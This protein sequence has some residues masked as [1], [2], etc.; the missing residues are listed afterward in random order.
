M[1]EPAP[2]LLLRLE[3]PVTCPQRRCKPSQRAGLVVLLADLGLGRRA[4]G[5]D[6]VS[7]SFQPVLSQVPTVLA[8]TGKRVSRMRSRLALKQKDEGCC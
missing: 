1:R 8:S 4:G 2:T 3:I 6:R 5:R 7:G